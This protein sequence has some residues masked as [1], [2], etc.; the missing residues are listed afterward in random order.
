MAI[1]KRSKIKK[2]LAGILGI[3]LILSRSFYKSKKEMF[4][5]QKVTGI[6]FHNPSPEVF[7]RSI[8]WLIKNNCIFI[9]TDQ[10]VAI[11]LH[12]AAL[13][14]RAVWITFD[15]GW[16]DN[17]KNVLPTL[18]KYKIPVTF[19][20]STA[21]VEEGFFWFSV[22][23]KYNQQLPPPF[24]EDVKK[25]WFIEETKRKK[26][27]A[28]LLRN[29]NGGIEREAMTVE[30]IKSISILPQVTIGAHT[31]NHAITTNCTLPE[32]MYEIKESQQKLMEWTGKKVKFFAYP[33]GNVGDKEKAILQQNGFT[34]ATTIEKSRIS[35]VQDL[36]VVPRYG[37]NDDAFF[38]EYLC[39][40]TGAWWNFLDKF[41]I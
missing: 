17:M 27:V 26:I 28:E 31:V 3:F 37:V 34:L 22:V 38:S 6:F 30:D 8:R 5:G 4:S 41:K 40:M 14:P 20:I 10:L 24:K 19:F 18:Q 1:I 13:P 9:T 16:K 15:D 35:P 29:I 25:L 32:L 7:G 33:N 39:Q 36:Y 23:R 2:I 12:K 11:L 21:P